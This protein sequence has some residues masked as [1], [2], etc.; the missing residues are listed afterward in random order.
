MKEK[1][2]AFIITMILFPFILALLCLRFIHF[3]K[4][5]IYDYIVV[6]L[7]LVFLFYF[8]ETLFFMLDDIIHSDNKKRIVYVF[9]IPFIYIPLY[10]LKNINLKDSFKRKRE[11][12]FKRNI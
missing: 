5:N 10:Y 1:E 3:L 6:L 2:N 12:Y 8:I 7:S 9:L 4:S 11:F